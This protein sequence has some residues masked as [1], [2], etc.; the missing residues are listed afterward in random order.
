MSLVQLY[1]PAC[2]RNEWLDQ[3]ESF[4]HPLYKLN[5]NM[6][7]YSVKC[8][9]QFQATKIDPSRDGHAAQSGDKSDKECSTSCC[10]NY[11]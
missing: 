11:T 5:V 6:N 3:V 8:A 10:S 4:F 7:N 1:Q 9:G 2:H